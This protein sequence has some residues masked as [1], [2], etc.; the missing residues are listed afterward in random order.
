MMNE[1]KYNC[2]DG[3]NERAV[4][5]PKEETMGVKAERL[6]MTLR[7][8]NCKLDMITRI[9]FA[10]EPLEEKEIA[11]D[12]LNTNMDFSIGYANIIISKLENIIER[13]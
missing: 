8:A 13:L 1:L 7:D 12:C 2:C 9:L 4:T 6:L 3:P 10:T 11:P 5:V